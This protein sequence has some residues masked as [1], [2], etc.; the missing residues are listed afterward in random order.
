[1]HLSVAV[2]AAILV[3]C[4][5]AV[6]PMH[7]GQPMEIAEVLAKDGMLVKVLEKFRNIIKNGNDSLG[8]PAL[9]PLKMEH[10]DLN[11]KEGGL[12]E[13]H[14]A[15]D[16]LR[17]H[18]L[19]TYIINK[20]DLAIVGLLA[21]VSLTWNE[22]DLMTNYKITSGKIADMD[23]YGSGTLMAVIKGLTVTVD[24][25]I[26]IKDGGLYAK[27]LVLHAHLKGL[28]FKITGLYDD[29]EMSKLVSSIVSDV[30]P[31]LIEDYQ[32]KLSNIGS[33]IVL[34]LLNKVL[35]NISLSSILG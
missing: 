33:P 11:V 17:A 18:G 35:K 21:N 7:V 3:A 32:E 19:S 29:A 27:E 12:I 24:M 20:G 23:V 4:H 5:A 1:M 14:G 28:N 31:G 6:P 22:I 2:I 9:D 15:L 25:K 34:K 13:L 10:V 8:I 26:G 16:N 30:A